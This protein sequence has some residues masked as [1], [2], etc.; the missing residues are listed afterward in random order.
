MRLHAE[1]A[2]MG[3][4]GSAQTVQRYLAELRGPARR[5]AS[6]TLRYETPRGKQAQ[7]DWTDGRFEWHDRR[8]TVYAF[9]MVLSYSRMRFVHFTTSMRMGE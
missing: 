3:Y 6:T 1:I 2:A 5:Q 4:A 9:V 8:I 7:A